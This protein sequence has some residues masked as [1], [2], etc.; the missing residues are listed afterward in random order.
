ML[1]LTRKLNET[2]VI[3]GDIRVTVVGIR[4]NQVRLGIVAPAGIVVLREELVVP[5]ETAGDGEKSSAPAAI[6]TA[7]LACTSAT[8]ARSPS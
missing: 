8:G 6:T 2:I 7:D 5:I 1:V 4:G 3:D